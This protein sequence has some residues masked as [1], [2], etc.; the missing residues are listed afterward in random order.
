V[1]SQNII[2]ILEDGVVGGDCGDQWNPKLYCYDIFLCI[3]GETPVVLL[4]VA[5]TVF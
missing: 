5:V 4:Q 1:F 2:E 3:G